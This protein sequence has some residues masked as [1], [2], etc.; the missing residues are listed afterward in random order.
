VDLNGG[1]IAWD[2]VEVGDQM[3]RVARGLVDEEELAGCLRG[4]I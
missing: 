2:V 1:G 3:I 4:Q